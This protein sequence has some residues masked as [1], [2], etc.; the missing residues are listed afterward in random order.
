VIRRRGRII[1]RKRLP[2]KRMPRVLGLFA[3]WPAAGQVKTRLA[4]A[5]SPEWAARVADAFLR[6]SLHRL[7][8]VAAQRVLAFSPGDVGTAFAEVVG[9]RFALEP[10]GEGDLGRRMDAFFGRHLKTGAEAVI[11]LGTDSPTVPL[12][13][14]EQAFRELEKADVVLGPATD[15]GYYLIGCRRL[16]PIFEGI[17]WGESRV[18]G[19]TVARLT[20]PAWRLALLPPWYDVDTP[21]DWL[22][23][24]GHVAALARSGIELDVPHTLELLRT[25]D[26]HHLPC[27]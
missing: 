24:R 10:Q 15:G 5:F 26:P 16:P 25:S 18:L 21:D 23:L 17:A 12:A 11:L 13:Y 22:M 4:R 6:D 7:A 14:V 9:D 20:D 3:K 27:T 19:D 8:R 2:E 1:A